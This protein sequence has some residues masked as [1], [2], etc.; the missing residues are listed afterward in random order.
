M[1]KWNLD[2]V[3]YRY[4]HSKIPT[5]DKIRGSFQIGK[6]YQISGDSGSGK[7]TLLALFAGLITCCS[8][9]LTYDHQEIAK[10]D[11][12]HY[13]SQEVDCLFQEGS[14]LK[15]SALAN[16][17]METLLSGRKVDK[18]V[19]IRGLLSIGLSEKQLNIPLTK[20]SK[21]DQQLVALAKLLMKKRAQLILVDE[22]EKVFSECG[23]SFAMNKLRSLSLQEK[24]CFIFTTQSTQSVKF[25]DEL[26]GL[27]GGKLLFIKEQVEL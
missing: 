4:K 26:W 13:R 9:S 2:Q 14:L 25:A 6:S 15:D 8:G 17:E 27:N 16:L 23:V 10:I 5:F 1:T 20:L 24:K 3:N 12:N 19:L 22:P 18:D 7:S 21:K 11:R